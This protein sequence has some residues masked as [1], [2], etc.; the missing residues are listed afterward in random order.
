MHKTSVMQIVVNINAKGANIRA[1]TQALTNVLRSGP[2]L[3]A[4]IAKWNITM[5]AT[6]M[7]EIVR[8]ACMHARRHVCV[9]VRLLNSHARMCLSRLCPLSFGT[10][11]DV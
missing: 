6:E 5:C 10:T 1:Y 11:M 4:A 7:E 9:C 2:E 8:Y 3:V